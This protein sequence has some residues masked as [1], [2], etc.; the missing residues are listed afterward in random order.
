MTISARQHEDKER[1]RDAS[2]I[3]RVI[4]E[5]LT[6]KAKGRE[7]LGLCPFHD[8]HK[9]SM[10]VAPSKQIFKCFSCGAGGDVFAF[11]QK[12]HSMEFREALEY[13]AERAGIE[14]TKWQ[15]PAAGDD[16]APDGG[17]AEVTR[18]DLVRASASAC[19]FFRTMLAH[20]Q[21]GEVGRALI[22]RRGISEAMVEAFQVGLSPDRW[23]GLLLTIQSQGADPRPFQEAG[24]LKPRE[25]GGV[26]DAFR[27]RLIFPIQDQLGRVIAFGGRRIREEDDPKYLNSPESRVF[28]K[29]GTLYGLYQAS[30]SIQ[31]GRTAI[32]TEGYTDTIAC[33]QHGFGNAVAT[34]GTALTR[35]HAAVLRRLC[36]TL[37]LLFDGDQ[38]GQKAA[39]RA[40][41]VFFGEQ[42]DV[43]IATLSTVTDAKDP[44]ELL[45]REGGAD[46][47]RR[48]LGAAPG[49]LQYRYDRIQRAMQGAGDAAL[50]RA[51][52]EELERL[53][54]L[55]LNS[56]PVLWRM[57]IIKR[58]ARIT[59]M[60]E[61][62]L[63]Q[64][65]P[66]GRGAAQ[67]GRGGR[68]EPV[69]RTLSHREQALGCLLCLPSLWDGLSDADREH[70]DAAQ[71]ESPVMGAIADLFAALAA[72][73]EAPDFGTLSAHFEALDHAEAA[74][75]LQ[76][77]QE[78][79]TGGDPGVLERFFR[80][81]LDLLRSETHMP[82]PSLEQIRLSRAN[83]V[84]NRRVLPRPA[85]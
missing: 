32:I 75:H 29:A 30:R 72:A 77:A 73:G 81:C 80:D 7:Y 16:G 71:F 6:L 74:T 31:A 45:K 13:L 67:P 25:S 17:A 82:P 69:R 26:Y 1:V 2:D 64:S 54:Q 34:L 66:G 52:R 5:H 79:V 57:R 42:L 49:I 83:R 11:I 23:D 61:A 27:H 33:H 48:A 21:H 68:A 19:N 59:G 58:L 51:T 28:Q 84:P 24:L 38:A 63:A 40:V 62:A 8:D 43:R 65:I 37:V 50:D 39:D 55:G 36:D 78:Q 10:Q 53:S 14:L 20:P 4:G 22:A 70:F 15:R 9:P 3:V 56:L 35:Q 46:L 76:T 85:G 41:E 44:D 60:S 18:S 12:Y 47:L